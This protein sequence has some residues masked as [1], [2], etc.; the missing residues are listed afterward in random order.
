MTYLLDTCLI[1]ELVAKQ[2][3]QQVLDWLDLQVP[4]TLYISVITIGE[5]AKGISKLAASKRKESLTKWLNE[6]L[7]NRFEGRILSIDIHLIHRHY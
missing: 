7:P 3:N 2:P 6:S 4:E 1:S 5:I